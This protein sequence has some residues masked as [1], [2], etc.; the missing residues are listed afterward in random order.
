MRKMLLNNKGFTLI[1][2]LVVVAIMGFLSTALAL[3]ITTIL[4]TF[5]K[6]R[7]VTIASRQVSNAGYW[8]SRDIQSSDTITRGG[9]GGFPL[10]I[11]R[12]YW[13]GDSIEPQEVI[14]NIADEGGLT[15]ITRDVTSG[16]SMFIARYIKGLDTDTNIVLTDK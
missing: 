12:Y 7:D 16:P 2:L 13:D 15:V 9:S 5:D 3:T 14:Y 6:G 11:S 1:E 8:I 4:G 10:Q